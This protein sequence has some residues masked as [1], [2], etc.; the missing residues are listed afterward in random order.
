[1][2]AYI[3]PVRRTESK[4]QLNNARKMA[5]GELDRLR[6]K[7]LKHVIS[8]MSK[9]NACRCLAAILSSPLKFSNI[10]PYL[11]KFYNM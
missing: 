10:S 1:M 6:L 3:V 8:C 2:I 5:N 11:Q 7:A 4:Y 9:N